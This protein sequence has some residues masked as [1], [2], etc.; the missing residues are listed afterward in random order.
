VKEKACK[1]YSQFRSG[2]PSSDPNLF[3]GKHE[4]GDDEIALFGG[5]TRVL[6][7]KLL[8]SRSP[9][10][11]QS[12]PPSISVPI[13]LDSDS[14]LASAERAPNV[15]PALMEYLSVFPRE[16]VSN[17]PQSHVFGYEDVAT[18]ST[19]EHYDYNA[20]ENQNTQSPWQH[21][22]SSL[23]TSST[24][25][26]S[27]LSA[28]TSSFPASFTSFATPY[29]FETTQSKQDSLDDNLLDL[30]MMTTDSGVDEHWMSFMRDTGLVGG[31]LNFSWLYGVGGTVSR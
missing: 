23:T 1:V 3:A 2:H 19:L 30:G 31:R 18:S 21:Q 17:A 10:R 20:G 12:T 28:Q 7:S 15:H 11:N 9:K 29:E 13:G 5:Q 14:N 4:H 27:N 24:S 26:Q 22:S 6:V 16:Y 25:L 8:S